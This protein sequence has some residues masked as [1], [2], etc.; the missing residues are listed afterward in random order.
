MGSL[1]LLGP[2]RLEPVLR[3][4]LDRLAIRGQIAA[5]TAGWQEREGEDEELA[6]HLGRPLVDLR[7]HGRCDEVFQEDRELAEAHRAR[8]DHLRA[9]QQLYRLRLDYALEPARRL[10]RMGGD[11]ELLDSEREN[12]IK[13]IRMLDKRHTQQLAVVH[14]DFEDRYRPG[15]RPAVRRH[16][17]EINEIINKSSALTIAGG[18]VA[19]LVNRMRL[20][21][22]KEHLHSLPVFAWSAGA[23]SLADRIVLFHDS[24]PQGAGNA[25][26]L[27]VGLGHYRGLVPLPNARQRLRLQDP[28]RVSLFARRFAP[29]LC[30]PLDAKMSI[31]RS[32]GGWRPNSGTLKLT[33]D[34]RV[35]PLEVV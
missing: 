18:H 16:R 14:R 15:K 21:G 11:P 6:E 19:V 1:I 25:E 12:A 3:P 28:V 30:V 29:D 23:M 32:I 20:F 17:E 26:V 4:E 5:I 13:A 33:S 10:M 9:M 8:Q 22:I 35:I 27:D 34:G 31:A 7:L 2:Q 24:P